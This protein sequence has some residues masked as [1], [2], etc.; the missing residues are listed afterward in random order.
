MTRFPELSIDLD[1]SWLEKCEDTANGRF[2]SDG[3]NRFPSI[4]TVLGA[5]DGE[6]RAAL[7]AWAERIGQAE[8]DRIGRR[9]G[10]RGTMVHDALEA[11]ILGADPSTIPN[12]KNPM[13]L[14][15]FLQIASALTERLEGFYF[16][17]APLRSNF[18]GVAGRGDL[19]G[20]WRC[21]DGK[22]RRAIVDF[23]TSAKE[24]RKHWIEGYFLQESFYS[25]A[26]EE[27][28]GAAFPVLVTIIGVDGSKK[29]QIFEE[30]RSTW[31][32]VLQERIAEYQK[33]ME[34]S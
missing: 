18:L 15:P 2:Y 24:K 11:W 22:I 17:E 28:T 30:R 26:T 20:L 33:R 25:I 6:A 12:L 10:D 19:A 16:L 5:T 14:D 23:K 8:A 32:P 31:A 7:Q 3:K 27:M 13:V 21:R 34:K 29:P 9:A 4:T 1:T